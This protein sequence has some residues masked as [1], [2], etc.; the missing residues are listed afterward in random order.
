MRT[1]SGTTR[2]VEQARE[3]T[4]AMQSWAERTI[5]WRVWERLLEN[6]FL[7]RSVALAAKAFVSLFPSIIVVA[8][9]LPDSLR[10]STLRTITRRAGLSGEGLRTVQS[11]FAS[12]G[13]VRRATGVLGLLLTFFYINSFVGAL[14]R[15]YTR[16]W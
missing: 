7:D 10:E 9:F 6:E 8:A 5:F 1:P 11:A 3:R 12:S 4:E 15:V 2:L 13:D 14:Q 16:A